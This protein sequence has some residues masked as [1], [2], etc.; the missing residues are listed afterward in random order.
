MTCHAMFHA[1]FPCW[2]FPSAHSGNGEAVSK[3]FYYLPSKNTSE[4]YPGKK[5]TTQKLVESLSL[6][7]S[8]RDLNM[9]LGDKVWW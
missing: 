2:S 9:A 4:K 6:E 1:G 8:R 5:Q 7:Y 3:Y